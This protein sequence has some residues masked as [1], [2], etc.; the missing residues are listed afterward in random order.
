[1]SRSPHVLLASAALALIAPG[2]SAGAQGAAPSVATVSTSSALLAPRA[3][4]R[5]YTITMAP[6]AAPSA[7]APR[8][9]AAEG[10]GGGVGRSVRAAIG[11]A[12][13][14]AVGGWIGYFGAQVA[15]SDWDRISASDKTSLRQ[16]Y[17]AA[18]VGA[19]AI[20]GYFL[21]PKGRREDRFPTPFNVPARTGRLLLASAELRRA[22]ATNVLEAVELARPEWTQQQR[23]DEAKHGDPSSTDPVEKTSVVVYVGDEKVGALETLRDVAIPEVSELRFYDARD[24][25]RR[26][27]TEH[28]Y[29][30]IEIVPADAAS[31]S[32]A[33]PSAP[34]ATR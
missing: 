4:P 16:G 32:A 24:A 15:N 34:D 13:G 2:V 10:S 19:G 14:A 25:R 29:G 3:A 26:W 5:E 20:I 33:A 31:T 22:I 11:V 9:R 12:V 17:T 6:I 8:A 7:I 18:G 27:G 30:A 21:R 28:R 1:M 23:A